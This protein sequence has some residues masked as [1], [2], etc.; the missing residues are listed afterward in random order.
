[1]DVM[2]NSLQIDKS[3]TILKTDT[4]HLRRNNFLNHLGGEKDLLADKIRNWDG[5]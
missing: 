5:I 3:Y 1:M 2:E 4:L